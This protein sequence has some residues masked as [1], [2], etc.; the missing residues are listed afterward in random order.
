MKIKYVQD[1]IEEVIKILE[2][3]N[4]HDNHKMYNQGKV[5]KAYDKLFELRKELIQARKGGTKDE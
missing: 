4:C 3:I 2:N 1:V 5:N